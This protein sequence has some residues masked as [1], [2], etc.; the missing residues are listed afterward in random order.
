MILDQSDH[1]FICLFNNKVDRLTRS[2]FAHWCFERSSGNSNPSMKMCINLQETS[3]LAIVESF[4]PDEDDRDAFLFTFRFF[5]QKKDC[6]VW[7]LQKL[8][9]KLPFE[10]KEKQSFNNYLKDVNVC[11]DSD[12]GIYE[13]GIHWTHKQIM[14]NILYGSLAHENDDKKLIV[15]RWKAEPVFWVWVEDMFIRILEFVFGELIQLRYLN[16]SLLDDSSLW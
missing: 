16:T 8:Y 2:R 3:K 13:G 12:S 14:E 10:R 1:E 9:E 7:D 11:L 6:N 4:V 5:V 15:D